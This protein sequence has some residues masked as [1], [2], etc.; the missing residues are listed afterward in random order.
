M[1]IRL[2]SP[3]QIAEMREAGKLVRETYAVL[4]EHVVD[5]VTTAELDRIAEEFMRRRGAIPICKG[6]GA[7][8]G[9][10]GQPPRPPFPAT[11]TTNINDV[12]CHGIPG[13]KEHLRNGD[14]IGIDVS[15]L[16]AG[17]IG[18]ACETYAVG[19]IDR[20]SQRLINV[21]RRCLELGLEQARAGSH[22]G[23]IGAAIQ[24]YAEAEGFSVVRELS[25]HGVGR[26][27]H[28]GGLTVLHYGVKGTGLKLQPGMVFTIEPMIN[29]GRR[30]IK[31]MPDGWTIRTADGQRSAQFEHT[32]AIAEDGPPVLL[33]L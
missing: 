10:R 28:E 2:K 30:E 12:I 32:V 3:R 25:G 14:I 1:A 31:L 9:R 17:W 33:T 29:A 20:E 24:Q 27:L 5:G 13:P 11:L 6:Y 23:D 16:Y 18:D 19:T 26:T 21:T 4:Q 7:Q 8:P 15:I 22:M